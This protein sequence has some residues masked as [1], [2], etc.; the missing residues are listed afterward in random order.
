MRSSASV[1]IEFRV[2]MIL[3]KEEEEEMKKERNTHTQREERH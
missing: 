1:S 2:H 3:R